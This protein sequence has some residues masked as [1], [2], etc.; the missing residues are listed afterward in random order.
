MSD[1]KFPI[2]LEDI[3]GDA[4]KGGWEWFDQVDPRIRELVQVKKDL[5]R[6]E[7]RI[8]AGAWAR[9]A[10]TPGGRKALEALFDSTLRRTVF[11]V[12][13]GD[14]VNPHNK[15]GNFREGQNAVAFEIARQ[16]AAGRGDKRKPKPRET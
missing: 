13:L 7:A 3:V 9:F 5:A 2:S 15:W 10:E 16:I 1:P 4:A 6:E 11:F 14:D 12:Q 8:V